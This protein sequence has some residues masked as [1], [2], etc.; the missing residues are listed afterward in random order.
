MSCA[1]SGSNAD[2]ITPHTHIWESKLL[3]RNCLDSWVKILPK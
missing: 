3:G 1:L 2:N